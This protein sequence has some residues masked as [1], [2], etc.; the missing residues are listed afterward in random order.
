MSFLLLKHE[1]W[2]RNVIHVE[3]RVSYVIYKLAHGANF[4]VC[5]YL[6][7]IKKFTTLLVLHEMVTIVNVVFGKLISW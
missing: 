3:I 4:L 1:S 7:I 2:Y 5:T 6:F